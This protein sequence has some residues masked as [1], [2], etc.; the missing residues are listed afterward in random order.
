MSWKMPFWYNFNA[1]PLAAGTANAAP[2]ASVF[3]SIPLTSQPDADFE[4]LRLAYTNTDPRVYLNFKDST[5]KTFNDDPG[6]DA[7]LYCGQ[8]LNLG[9]GG[10]ALILKNLA[11]PIPIP[12]NTSFTAKMADFSGAQNNV[13]L[14]MHGVKDMPGVPPWVMRGRKYKEGG[15]Q[16][17]T[18][19]AYSLG[20]AANGN[21]QPSIAAPARRDL[22]I[23]K[24]L[25]I[26]TG[27]ATIEMNAGGSGMDLQNSP[28]HLDN[29]T[30]NIAGYNQLLQPIYIPALSS[31][32][33]NIVD[34]SGATNNVT[35]HFEGV[36]K[37]F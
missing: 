36:M 27:A 20:I 37:E 28:I 33:M 17:W 23:T 6:L 8:L 14:C 9:A 4:A 21:A 1:L 3:S 16:H 31:F 22:F 32:W 19:P 25:A 29:L 13:R 5:G 34:L 12:A 30:G 7:R 10:N 26:R 11:K 2:T 35:L 18:V 24:I 15:E